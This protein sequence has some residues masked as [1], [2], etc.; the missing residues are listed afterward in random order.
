MTLSFLTG[1]INTLILES[2]LAH[3]NIMALSYQTG[4]INTLILESCLAHPNIMA[5]S[6]QTGNTLIEKRA[7]LIIK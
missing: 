2:C 6:Y 7:L 5:L 4:K 1:K 3:P